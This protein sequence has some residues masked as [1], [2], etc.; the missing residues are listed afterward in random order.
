MLFISLS[1]HINRLAAYNGIKGADPVIREKDRAIPA[2][3]Y[4]MNGVLLDAMVRIVADGNGERIWGDMYKIEA[5]T[6]KKTPSD[7]FALGELALRKIEAVFS[8]R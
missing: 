2:E 1:D 8:K 5:V 4:M 6:Q 3:V 7:V